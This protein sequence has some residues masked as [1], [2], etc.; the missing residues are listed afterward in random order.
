MKLMDILEKT[1]LNSLIYE[2]YFGLIIGQI[3]GK[4]GVSYPVL[5]SN[6]SYIG[7]DTQENYLTIETDFN[8]YEFLKKHLAIIGDELI[9]N[10]L[11][12]N[13]SKVQVLK[14]SNNNNVYI[15][16]DIVYTNREFKNIILNDDTYLKYILSNW[17]EY[18]T[19][20]DLD[21]LSKWGF[22]ENENY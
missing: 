18:E 13:N 10:Y 11:I 8:I 15:I 2:S 22:L 14:N 6:V 4:N 3:D 20:F 1:C 17:N 12:Y 7:Y 16:N 19:I 9:E 5:Y 21:N